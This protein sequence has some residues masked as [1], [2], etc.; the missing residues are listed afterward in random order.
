MAQQPRL[1]LHGYV[2]VR[3]HD[4]ECDDADYA[5]QKKQN[6]LQGAFLEQTE[7]AQREH[8]QNEQQKQDG[9][10]KKFRRDRG[11]VY[12]VHECHFP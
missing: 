11:N 6:A 2:P 1:R 5:R 3:E 8:R 7:H 9:H 10:D 12:D 4:D